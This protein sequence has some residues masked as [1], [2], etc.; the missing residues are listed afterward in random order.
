MEVRAYGC[1]VKLWA[2]VPKHLLQ[3]AEAVDAAY[4]GVDIDIYFR[5][6][7]ELPEEAI[8][9]VCGWP[10]PVLKGRVSD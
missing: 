4:N 2:D 1:D 5:T 3:D 10:A 9:G 8:V 6:K 7:V